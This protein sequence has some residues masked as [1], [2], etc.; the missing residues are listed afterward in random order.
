MTDRE[1]KR[2]HYRV[3]YPI[4]ERPRLTIE[5]SQFEILELSEGGLRMS[6]LRAIWPSTAPRAIDAEI[7]LASGKTC[8][9]TASFDRQED[10]EYVYTGLHGIFSNDI[11]QEQ[12]YLMKKY[13]SFGA[14]PE[15]S[16]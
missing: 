2:R 1:Q 13:P 7:T 6:V 15:A 5:G 10:K 11:I 8:T 14:K 9:I 16:S 3:R 12:R 4:S